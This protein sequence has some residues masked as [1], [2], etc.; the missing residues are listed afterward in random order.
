MCM[1]V[2][3][4]MEWDHRPPA[5]PGLSLFNVSCGRIETM[6][7]THMC[8]REWVGL[9]HRMRAHV[10]VHCVCVCPVRVCMRAVCAFV[11]VGGG[12][13]FVQY[14]STFFCSVLCGGRL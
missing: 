13:F 10:C 14:E 9:F 11:C 3:P 6:V 2:Q 12:C 1:S 8:F 4:T 7:D 5:S